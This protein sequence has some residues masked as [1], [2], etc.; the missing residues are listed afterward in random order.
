MQSAGPNLHHVGAVYALHGLYH[1]QHMRCKTR[2]YLSPEHVRS[3]TALVRHV[4]IMWVGV[5]VWGVWVCVCG[6]CWC[7]CVGSVGVRV[8]V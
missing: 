6:E 1:S 4:T 5:S 3:L 2:I 8:L 7:A